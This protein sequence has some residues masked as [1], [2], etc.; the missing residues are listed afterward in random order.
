MWSIE[1][2]LMLDCAL[3]VAI[4]QNVR[5][6]SNIWRVLRLL[7]QL[8]DSTSLQSLFNRSEL[9]PVGCCD[10][11]GTHRCEK[12]GVLNK[13]SH[14]RAS[15]SMFKQQFNSYLLCFVNILSDYPFCLGA[16]FFSR[17]PL[18]PL[19]PPIIV[20]IRPVWCINFMFSAKKKGFPGWCDFGKF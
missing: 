12:M 16:A 3:F 2:S 15:S 13:H 20:I 18:C 7:G 19:F 9:D 5:F 14:S 17:P 10:D 11:E 4:L 8:N 1:K 6:T